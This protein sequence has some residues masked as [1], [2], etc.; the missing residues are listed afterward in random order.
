VRHRVQVKVDDGPEG[1]SQEKL[2]N[3]IQH[4]MRNAVTRLVQQN[5][6]I[7]SSNDI[8]RLVAGFRT[9]TVSYVNIRDPSYEELKRLVDPF[10]M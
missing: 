3:Q 4:Q 2:K 10:V 1:C 6:E 7:P 8:S 9:E 5:R